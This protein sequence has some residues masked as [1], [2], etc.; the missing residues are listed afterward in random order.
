M[1]GCGRCFSLRARTPVVREGPVEQKCVAGRD[2][3]RASAHAGQAYDQGAEKQRCCHLQILVVKLSRM[4][5]H[6]GGLQQDAR[7]RHT[8]V[9]K[10]QL[11]W[12]FKLACIF[13]F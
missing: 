3:A 5:C 8:H 12:T 10:P 13:A 6:D 4:P 11:T 7:N 1:R 2:G 9:T